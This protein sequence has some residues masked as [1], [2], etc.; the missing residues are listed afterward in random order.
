MYAAA[1]TQTRA[2]D[3]FLRPGSVLGHVTVVVCLM[4]SS[5]CSFGANSNDKE[6]NVPSSKRRVS[7]ASAAR[8]YHGRQRRGSSA[9]GDC[10]KLASGHAC[11]VMR[12]RAVILTV[13]AVQLLIAVKENSRQHRQGE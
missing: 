1:A 3:P 9:L 6:P 12:V 13:F 10:S 2:N 11:A 8:E 5:R 7:S 4:N